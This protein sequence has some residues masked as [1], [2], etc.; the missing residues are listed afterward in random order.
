M[1][2]VAASKHNAALTI[3]NEDHFNRKILTA[4][5]DS[6]AV[7]HLQVINVWSQS[8]ICH[9]KLNHADSECTV[10]LVCAPGE[11]PT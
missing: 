5:S 6:K 8:E 9:P 11:Q 4:V 2:L 3:L 1:T 10:L 7:G